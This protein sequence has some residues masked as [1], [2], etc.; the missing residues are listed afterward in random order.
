[1][2]KKILWRNLGQEKAFFQKNELVFFSRQKNC[3]RLLKSF[4]FPFFNLKMQSKK[5]VML[6]CVYIYSVPTYTSPTTCFTFHLF[7]CILKLVL[8]IERLLV[9]L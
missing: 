5:L 6:D 2:P 9:A 1:M 7:L 4:D 3:I 8:L